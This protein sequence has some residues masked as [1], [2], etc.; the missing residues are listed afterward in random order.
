MSD[1]NLNKAAVPV[2]IGFIMDG[3][4]R[5]AKARNKPRNQGH[6]K[7]MSAMEKIVEHCRNI[8]V[9]CVTV[10]AFSTENWSRPKEEVDHLMKMF[11]TY[12]D[13][14]IRDIKN[15]KLN[16]YKDSH[17]RFIGDLSVF[18]DRLR[19][20]MEY[21]E[22]ETKGSDFTFNIA[23]NYGGRNELVHAVNEFISSNPNKLITERDIS[24][25]LYTGSQPDPDLIIRTAGESRLSNFLLWQSSYSEIYITPV[26]WPDFTPEELDKALVDFAK[27]TRRFG[28]LKED[29]I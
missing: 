14:I 9:K 18:K 6:N 10:Y 29:E 2:H 4:G 22:T 15:N 21:I 5:W 8:G 13:R 20:K 28:G 23:V 19:E 24:A 3:N 11:E 1:N 26:C 17:I 25:L 7:G 12:A 16:A 27:R